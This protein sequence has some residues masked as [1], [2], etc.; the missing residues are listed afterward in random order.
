MR[1]AQ[2]VRPSQR[3]LAAAKVVGTGLAAVG[4][5]ALVA[6]VDPNQPG[7]YPTCPSLALTG[8]Y[9]P[10]CGTLRCLHF[11][12]TG[13]PVMAW[14]MN[15]LA[16]VAIPYLV[17]SWLSWARRSVTGR[18]RAWLAPPWVLWTVLVATLA[19]W[20]LRNVPGLEFLG[21]VRPGA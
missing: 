8:F 1:L 16:I 13:D 17:W 7:H 3:Q 10:G 5:L 4:V 14:R 21:P 19:Y 11:L 20:V 12:A 2:S 18:P 6:V 15:P 9:C